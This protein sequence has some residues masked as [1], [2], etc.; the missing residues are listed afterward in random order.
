MVCCANCA[1]PH[2]EWT[3]ALTLSLQVRL[4]RV[5]THPRPLDPAPRLFL[6]PREWVHVLLISRRGT[7]LL[8][9]SR[10]KLKGGAAACHWQVSPVFRLARRSRE[11]A[12]GRDFPIYAFRGVSHPCSNSTEV[13]A[14]SRVGAA[15]VNE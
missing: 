4:L 6:F 12:G 10:G 8:L 14:G 3:S 15:A 9:F 7:S 5:I 2:A 13:E 11:L 1:T